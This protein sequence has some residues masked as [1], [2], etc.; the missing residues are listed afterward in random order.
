MNVPKSR[1]PLATKKYFDKKHSTSFCDLEILNDGNEGNED[2][3]IQDLGFHDE[4]NFVHQNP[5][6]QNNPQ[7]PQTPGKPSQI[8]QLCDYYLLGP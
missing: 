2:Q 7:F 1:K 5:K 3:R 8:L 6:E 4:K